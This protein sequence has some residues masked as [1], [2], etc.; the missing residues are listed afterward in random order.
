MDNFDKEHIVVIKDTNK[1]HVCKFF[2]KIGAILT[3]IRNFISNIVMIVIIA[4]LIASYSL[5]SNFSEQS[6][7]NIQANST[8]NKVNTISS[9]LL[10]VPLSGQIIE[11]PQAEPGINELIEQQLNLNNQL[12]TRPLL[13]ILEALTLAS[14]DKNIKEVLF[15]FSYMSNISLSVA[16]RISKKIDELNKAGVKTTAIGYSYTQSGYAIAVHCKSIILD[17]FGQIDIRGLSLSS[18]YYKDLLDK[19]KITPYVFKVGSHKSAVEPYLLNSMSEPVKAEYQ[20]IVNQAWD[21]YTQK[22]MAN[23]KVSE[24]EIL[25]NPQKYLEQLAKLK[26]DIALLQK[27]NNLVDKV[28]NIDDYLLSLVNVYGKSYDNN[29]LPNYIDYNDY[30]KQKR[31][32]KNLKANKIAVVYGIGTII[33]RANSSSDFSPDNILPILDDILNDSSYKAM[34]LYLNTPGGSVSA[35]ELIRRKVSMISKKMPVI[36]SM[37]GLCASG[38]YWVSTSAQTLF[39]TDS[40][41]TGSIGVFGLSFGADKLLNYLGVNQDGVQ[42]H[43]FAQMPIA[44][45]MPQEQRQLIELSISNTY[46]KFINLVS[47]SRKLN[48]KDEQN[49][50]QGKVFMAKDALKMGLIDKIGTIDDAIDFAIKKSGLNKDEVYVDQMSAPVDEFVQ[51]VNSLFTS[52]ISAYI[53]NEA[54]YILKN[55]SLH[56]EH[57]I[58]DKDGILLINPYTIN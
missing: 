50:A 32:I 23:R 54:L 25:A 56:Q 12:K 48:A 7:L 4:L 31:P 49:F 38:G 21:I 37:N 46:D 43:V 42:T 14:K 33:D 22:I 20:N 51:I 26:G 47:T 45:S 3:F 28:E 9:H 30:L 29:I 19:A 39:A 11:Y 34:V 10:Y 2:L 24:D 57:S 55:L 13:D 27:N 41:L 44:N 40:T 5:Y 36:V 8:L 35:S 15:D 53:P 18:L 58:F 1:H 17:S 52:Q 6:K 16:D